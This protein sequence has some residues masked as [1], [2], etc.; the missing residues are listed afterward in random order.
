MLWKTQ[1][2]KNQ[3]NLSFSGFAKTE[4]GV[5]CYP[6]QPVIFHFNMSELA[7]YWGFPLFPQIFQHAGTTVFHFLHRVFH[8]QIFNKLLP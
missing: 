1:K 5:F 3:E 6:L 2:L 4:I 8:M 7:E